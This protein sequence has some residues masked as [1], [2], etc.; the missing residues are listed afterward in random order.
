MNIVIKSI[1]IISAS[2]KLNTIFVRRK[3]PGKR[4]HLK[5]LDLRAHVNLLGVSSAF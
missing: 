3:L 2:A 1:V 5:D 4:S